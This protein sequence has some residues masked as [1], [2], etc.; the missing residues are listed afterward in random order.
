MKLVKTY[1]MLSLR[2][3]EKSINKVLKDMNLSIEKK[4]LKENFVEISAGNK[5]VMMKIKIFE[6]K[7]NFHRFG[8]DFIPVIRLEV[9]FEG[10]EESFKILEKLVKLYFLRGGG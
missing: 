10:P 3:S 8:I 5:D 2:D 6:K 9:D 4:E 1:R 7:E